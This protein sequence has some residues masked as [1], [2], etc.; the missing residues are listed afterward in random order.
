MGWLNSL[1]LRHKLTFSILLVSN[2]ASLLACAVFGAYDWVTYR[3]SMTRDLTTLGGVLANNSTA[4]ITFKDANTAEELLRGLRV[5]PHIVSAALYQRDGQRFAVYNPGLAPTS[6]PRAPA[7]D[8]ARFESGRLVLFLPVEL[9]SRR[10]GTLFMESDLYA[11]KAR[12]RFYASIVVMVLVI[13]LLVTLMVT[14][15]FQHAISE[16]ILALAQTA[17]RI[18]QDR[19]YALRVTKSSQDEVGQLTESFNAMLAG[20][21][22]RDSALRQANAALQGEIG[23]R[24]RAETELRRLNETLEQRVSERTAAAEQASRAKSD[25]LASM[26]HE[27]R[28]PLNSVIGFA[29]LLLKN[30]GAN[31]RRE[32]L[33]FVERIQTNGRHLL[34]L[35]N[36]ILDL[37]KVEAGRLELQLA[38]IE[39][40]R[41][42]DT[43]AAEF[44]GQLHGRDVRLAV[45]M[46]HPLAPLEA[47]AE[48]LRQVLINLIGNAVKFT[49]CG[50]VTVRV[51]AE[52]ATRRPLRID[53]IDTGI[54]IP[55]DKQALIFEAFRQA[56]ST[57]ARR[58]GGTGL[59]L[60]ISQALCRLMGY[61]I[62]VVSEEGCGSM[63]SV[64]LGPAG[65]EGAPTAK[66]ALPPDMHR[67]AEPSRRLVLVIDDEEDARLLL[68]RMIEDFGYRVIP[69]GSGEEGLRLA[70]NVRPDAITLDLIMPGMDGWTVLRRLKEDAELSEIPTIVVSVVAGEQRGAVLGAVDTLQ[71]PVSREDIMRILKH[72]SRP[73]ILVVEDSEED[74][75]LLRAILEREP[76]E[77]RVACDGTEAL[78]MLEQFTPDVILLDLFMPNMDGMAFLDVLR[79]R[80]GGDTIPVVIITGMAPDDH[81]RQCL[82]QWTRAVLMKHDNLPERLK[83]VLD[84]VLGVAKPASAAV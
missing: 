5:H 49:E 50:T 63:F 35:I 80:T 73:R 51:V 19:N 3:E 23:E 16:P 28:T 79:R 6:A 72:C 76:A 12:L 38:P 42:I 77:V 56:D 24:R 64:V 48:K 44:E 37:S 62:D 82:A 9:D 65:G 4:A 39:V 10:I 57:T 78:E 55:Q 27:L 71:K 22:N 45:D 61:R 1:P 25:F 26:S 68:S 52:A 34:A 11:L 30:K 54:G 74:R 84:G 41:M 47:D 31:L 20:I 60:T 2:L 46:P 15:V 40:D 29:N 75:R 33:T 36:Q 21:E 69:A 13:S 58:F 32:D 43:L 81:A 18:S 7:L 8:G 83:H 59:G 17:R 66:P 14:A 67:S 70:R 53:V